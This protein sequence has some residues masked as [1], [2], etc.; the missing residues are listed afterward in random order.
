MHKV[1]SML[2]SKGHKLVK[3]NIPDPDKLISM[4]STAMFANGGGTLHKASQNDPA[5]SRLRKLCFA[6]SLPVFIR[7]SVAWLIHRFISRPIGA[8][9]RSSTGCQ[10]T[11]DVLFLLK[12]IN[13]YQVEFA[14]AWSEAKLVVLICPGMPFPAPLDTTPDMLISGL[15]NYVLLYNVLDYPAGV[16]PV[17]KVS[18]ADVKASKDAEEEYRRKGDWLNAKISSQQEGTQ[19]LPIGLQVVGRPLCEVIVLRVMREIERGVSEA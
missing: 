6:L 2:Q 17:A 13:N 12:E 3:F 8:A 19:G 1:I 7:R 11:Q 16:L 5:N 4:S 9:I 10:S 15:T 14:K 18:A